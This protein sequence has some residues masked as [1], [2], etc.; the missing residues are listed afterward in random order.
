MPPG[1]REN[2]DPR[3]EP[4]GAPSGASG[5]TYARR[6]GLF[7]GT[8][9]VVGGIIGAGIFL[10]PAIVAARVGSARLTMAV[11]VLGGVVAVL[12]GFIY[13]ELGRRLPQAGGPYAY[14]RAG[15]GPLAGFLY[16][17]ALLL[18]VGTGAAAAVAFT[19]AS[20]AAT[21]FGLPA[22]AIVPLAAGAILAFAVLNLFGVQFGAWTQNVFVLLKLAALALLIVGGLGFAPPGPPPVPVDCASCPLPPAGVAAAVAAVGAALVPVLFAYGGWQQSNFVAEEIVEPER[23]LPRAL[24]LGVGVVVATYLLANT[25]YLRVLGVEGLALS[26]APAADTLGRVWGETGRRLIAIGVMLSTAG[27][28]NT[29]TLLSPRVYQ[30]MARDG[31]FFDGFARLHPRWRTPVVAIG[32]QAA[33]AVLLL[34]LGTYGKLLDYVVFADWIF[35][36]ATATA[37]VVLRRRQRP[38][39]RG[40]R[41]PGYPVTVW[42]FVAAA[43]YVVVGSVGSNPGNAVRGVG[44]LVAGIPVFLWWARRSRR[45]A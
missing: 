13:G 3:P 20:Y 16:A 9:A 38:P 17:W 31:L 24:M 23:N 5:V 25:A 2:Q 41:A 40:F 15:F 37:L 29:I 39:D 30:A 26:H 35:F 28:L 6:L 4:G 22:S 14:L 1:P 21:V 12:G 19:F 44:L 8:M 11:W 10:N 36:G 45:P 34:T 27:F 7:S 32:F 43:V 18:I 42:L 33:W